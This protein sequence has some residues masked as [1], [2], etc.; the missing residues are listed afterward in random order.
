MLKLT[1]ERHRGT[2][3][4]RHKAAFSL[5]KT[6]FTLL[7]IVIALA[8]VTIGIVGVMVIFPAGLRASQRAADFTT[9]ATLGAQTLQYITARGHG[10]LILEPSDGGRRGFLVPDEAPEVGW[11]WRRHWS[12]APAPLVRVAVSIYWTDRGPPEN[13]KKFITFMA[14]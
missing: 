12:Y 3:A 7:E 14:P 2:E 13:E 10:K 4:Q 6:G 9:A 8:I 1:K 11:S 5:G